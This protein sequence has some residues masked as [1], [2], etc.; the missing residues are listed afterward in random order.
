[1]EK[2]QLLSLDSNRLRT[3]PGGSYGLL[4]EYYFTPEVV[5][6]FP[7]FETL[8][9][10]ADLVRVDPVV[11]FPQ[12]LEN[13]AGLPGLND[14]FAVR[15]SGQIFIEATGDVTFYVTSD[16][17]TRLYIDNKPLIDNSGVH[18]MTEASKKIVLRKAGTTCVWSTSRTLVVLGSC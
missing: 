13:F 11:A 14:W 6:D 5:G 16:D 12:E 15:W 8:T 7:D 4:G 9:D 18:N 1:M 2:L 3:L 17:G 10:R